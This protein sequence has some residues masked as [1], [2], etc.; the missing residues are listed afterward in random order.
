MEN[1]DKEKQD[2]LLRIVEQCNSNNYGHADVSELIFS[3]IKPLF[4][5]SFQF[6]LK[7]WH[8][9]L[10]HV[11]SV[12]FDRKNNAHLRR[13]LLFVLHKLYKTSNDYFSNN[14][15]AELA[16]KKTLNQIITP[17]IQNLS[18][19]CDDET[20]DDLVRS[21]IPF[22]QYKQFVLKKYKC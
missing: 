16:T 20:E 22:V 8:T 7:I 4:K 15:S 18:S 6:P 17:V 5:D 21:T 9:L 13:Y 1:C 12:I 11:I 2:E 10:P 19:I 3:F 14:F